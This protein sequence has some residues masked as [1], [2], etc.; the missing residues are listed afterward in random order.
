LRPGHDIVIIARKAAAQADF[1]TL[2]SA[3]ARLLGRAH[4]TR[5]E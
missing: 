3:I 5:K 1:Q 4:L 2:S